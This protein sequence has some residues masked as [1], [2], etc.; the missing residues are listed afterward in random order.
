[1]AYKDLTTHIGL[2]N[3]LDEWFKGLRFESKVD[4]QCAVKRYFICR[5]QYLIVIE[6][7]PNMWVVKYKKWYEGCN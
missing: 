3:E 2:W 7:E 6:F 5:N 4:L 1:M